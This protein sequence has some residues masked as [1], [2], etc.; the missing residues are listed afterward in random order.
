MTIPTTGPVS[1]SAMATEYGLNQNN[2]SMRRISSIAGIEYTQVSNLRGKNYWDKVGSSMTTNTFSGTA[3]S[4]TNINGTQVVIRSVLDMDDTTSN[5][6]YET[7][8][9]AIGVCV[10][11][12]NGTVYARAGDGQVDV[13]NTEVSFPIPADWTTSESK[14]IL[15]CLDVTGT[16]ST[17]WVDGLRRST[18]VSSA[19]DS[20]AGSNLGGTGRVWDSVCETRAFT[21]NPGNGTYVLT[22]ATQ[23]GTQVWNGVYINSEYWPIGLYGVTSDIRSNDSVGTGSPLNGSNSMT[24]RSII[25]MSNNDNGIIYETGGTGRGSVFYVFG[26]KLYG[27]GGDGSPS[28]PSFEVSWTIPDSYSNTIPTQVLFTAIISSTSSKGALY[29]N[30]QLVA[31]ATGTGYVSLSGGNEGGTGD[32]YNGSVAENRMSS[33]TYTGTIYET[34]LWNTT[35]LT[36][37]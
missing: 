25:T 20:V 3:A 4:D 18:D 2:V 30:N 32:V 7:G 28:G 26:G 8:G 11:G 13:G 14:E 27:S 33:Y 35:N 34:L 21:F 29:V 15:I 23:Y 6:I 31:T 12:Y 16:Y 37:P 19:A 5:I 24:V 9:S 36:L 1:F 17:L 22:N 10:Y